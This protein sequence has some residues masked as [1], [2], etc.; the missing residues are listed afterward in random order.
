MENQSNNKAPIEGG[1]GQE[2]PD[3]LRVEKVIERELKKLEKIDDTLE[4][5]H[6]E[7]G[8]REL[9]LIVT[10]LLA[11]LY[12]YPVNT[13]DNNPMIEISP[14]S[15]KIPLRDAI[16]VF[17]TIIVAMYLVFLSSVINEFYLRVKRHGYIHR[18]LN[19]RS[20]KTT[21]WM[22]DIEYDIS[23]REYLFLP[24]PLHKGRLDIAGGNMSRFIVDG[25]VGFIFTMF[26]YAALTFIVYKSWQ[27]FDTKVLLIWNILCIVIM[28]LALGGALNISANKSQEM[29]F[30]TYPD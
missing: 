6:K 28:F 15:I 17:P 22:T 14:I 5:H 10:C 19:L 12:T 13:F 24:S 3:N 2:E 26:P 23:L 18:I 8:K 29:L 30:G 21:T 25:F 4:Q 16:R 27:L 7:R 11:L 1:L 9:I 20:S